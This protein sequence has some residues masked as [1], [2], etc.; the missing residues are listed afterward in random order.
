MNHLRVYKKLYEVPPGHV[1]IFPQYEV[2]SKKVDRDMM[3]MSIGWRTT[4]STTFLHADMRERL[5][6]QAIIPLPSGQLPPLYS[7]NHASFLKHKPFKP[8]P[9][10]TAKVTVDTWFHDSAVYGKSK[11]ERPRDV[12][13]VFRKRNTGISSQ[14]NINI[15]FILLIHQ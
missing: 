15:I 10:N 3:R 11:N 7:A 9:K 1:I 4:V 2:V 13:S 6:D 5:K 8:I 12:C 14:K